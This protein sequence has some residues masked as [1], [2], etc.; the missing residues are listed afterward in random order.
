MG[1]KL[2]K[3]L[4]QVLQKHFY[5]HISIRNV[6]SLLDANFSQ[7]TGI[8]YI[9]IRAEHFYVLRMLKSKTKDFSSIPILI[10]KILFY[11]CLSFLQL[12][13]MFLMPTLMSRNKALHEVSQGVKAVLHSLF[14]YEEILLLLYKR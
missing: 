9:Q 3:I 5:N 11:F 12:L 8:D 10:R 6:P 2:G 14:F 4:V 7:M 13:L 1:N